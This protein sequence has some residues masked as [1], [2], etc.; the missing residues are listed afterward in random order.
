[1]TERD[2]Y[3]QCKTPVERHMALICPLTVSLPM[4]FTDLYRSCVRKT[5]SR[6]ISKR[7]K[8]QHCVAY[9]AMELITVYIRVCV[10]QNNVTWNARPSFLPFCDTADYVVDR[11]T[12]LLTPS[13]WLL[14]QGMRMLLASLPPAHLYRP[15]SSGDNTFGSVRVSVRLSV[16]ALLF[17]PFDPWLW[18]LAWGWT[19][20]LASVGL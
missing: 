6:P 2:S 8:I 13:R 11:E 16:G 12:V 15:R 7:L 4:T 10:T 18:F 17:E 5:S 19:L 14:P 9:E 1:M 3:C 20:T